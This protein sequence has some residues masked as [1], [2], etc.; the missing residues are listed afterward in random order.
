MKAEEKAEKEK[1]GFPGKF[2]HMH[3]LP[4]VRII[5]LACAGKIMRVQVSA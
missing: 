4:C 5:K 1:L 3:E 2:M